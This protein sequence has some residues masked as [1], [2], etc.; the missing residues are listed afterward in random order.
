MFSPF[1]KMVFD[2]GFLPTLFPYFKITNGE[3][4]HKRRTK[5]KARYKFFYYGEITEQEKQTLENW[6]QGI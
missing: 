3:L 1:V 5:K 6:R 4:H 2:R